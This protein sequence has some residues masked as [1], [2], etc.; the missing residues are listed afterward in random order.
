MNNLGILGSLR[1]AVLCGAA[2]L[3]TVTVAHTRADVL[4]LY[5]FAGSSLASTDADPASVASAITLGS[6]LT[7]AAANR[8]GPGNP[9]LALRVNS[10]ETDGTTF[11]TAITANDLFTFSL[12]PGNGQRFTFQ[13]FT[14]DLATST[15]TLSTN[16]RL[17]ASINGS[18]FV[19][20]DS[21]MAFSSTSFATQTF[22]LSADNTAAIAAGA[23]VILR[24]VTFDDGNTTAA[25]T[26]F[27]NLTVNGTVSAIPEPATTALL[28]LGAAAILGA[29]LR[30]RL[31][32]VG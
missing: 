19:T 7:D 22:D 31:G 26:A 21:A 3:L 1:R 15:A 17:Q 6:G 16:I 20:L 14:V 12:T 29:A 28:A 2:A 9:D 25:Y 11:A 10:D 18:T 5:P 27:D 4:A 8:F 24:V 13:S 23:A 30:R 32:R